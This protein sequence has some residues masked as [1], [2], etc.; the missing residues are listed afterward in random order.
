MSAL[1]FEE[2]KAVLERVVTVTISVVLCGDTN[3]RLDRSEDVWIIRLTDLVMS[4]GYEQRVNQ[5][6]HD[7]NGI[8]D[9]AIARTDPPPQ[10]VKVTYV[11]LS[12]HL[13]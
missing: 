1:C 7:Q 10:I 13:V 8:L 2:L 6:T 5:P 9:I 11:G 3:V 4:F 12:D